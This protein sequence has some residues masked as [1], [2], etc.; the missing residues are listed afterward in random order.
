MVA[1][2]RCA[3]ASRIFTPILWLR[4]P[5]PSSGPAMK[6]SRVV[7]SVMP[8]I[9]PDRAPSACRW[10]WIASAGARHSHGDSRA[11]ASSAPAARWSLAGLPC[12]LRAPGGELLD[13]DR[14]AHQR[15]LR[16]HLAAHQRAPR[17]AA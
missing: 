5:M 14:A 17:R 3:D 16:V 4:A 12:L 6:A 15:G 9:L 10:L 13:H 2:T 1:T 8:A 7:W 11:H